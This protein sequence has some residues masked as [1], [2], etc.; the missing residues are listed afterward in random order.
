MT[1][2]NYEDFLE[3]LL[4]FAETRWS[5]KDGP[6]L[7]SDDWCELENLLDEFFIEKHPEDF[8]EDET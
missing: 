3:E 6:Q 5:V 4:E 1:E 2:Q 7:K 8:E